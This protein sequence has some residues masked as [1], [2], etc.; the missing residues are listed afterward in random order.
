M[1]TMLPMATGTAVGMDGA[2]VGA[3]GFAVVR[4]EGLPISDA[5]FQRM[6]APIP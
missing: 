5:R 6:E 3:S 4:D 1:V 2:G